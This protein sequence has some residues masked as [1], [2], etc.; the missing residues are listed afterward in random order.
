M[1]ACL[2]SFIDSDVFTL[3]ETGYRQGIL[4]ANGLSKISRGLSSINHQGM[5]QHLS[6]ATEMVL[7]E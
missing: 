4:C 6:L 1:L 2:V 5:L 7:M 3:E